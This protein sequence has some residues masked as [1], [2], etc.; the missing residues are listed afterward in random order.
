VRSGHRVGDLA[1][2]DVADIQ[3]D[4]KSW[5]RDL[6]SPEWSQDWFSGQNQVW[7]AV[8]T[9]AGRR[10]VSGPSSLTGEQRAALV[11]AWRNLCPD[12]TLT[13]RR[14]SAPRP[15]TSYD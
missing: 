3:V 14:R 12:A 11:S 5:A 15:L 4:R 13:E 1:A 10:Y 9:V 8:R 6:D 7:L 2:V